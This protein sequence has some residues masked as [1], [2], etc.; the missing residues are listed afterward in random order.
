MS[1]VQLHGQETPELVDRLCKERI[2]V[3]KTLFINGNPSLKAAKDYNPSA[4]LIE[5]AGGTLPGGNALDWDWKQVRKFGEAHP[6]VLAGGLSPINVTDAIQA[7]LP[8]VVDVSSG[9]ES[10]PGQKDIRKVRDFV[11]AVANT[12][13][14]KI[15]RKIY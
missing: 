11:A 1:A 15:F 14:S 5:H 8:D 4:F 13:I 3:T 12:K 10:I 2:L 9:V 6:L 7:A